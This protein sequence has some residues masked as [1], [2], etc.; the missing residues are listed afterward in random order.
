MFYMYA[1][2]IISQ[3]DTVDV[4]KHCSGFEDETGF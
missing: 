3:K 2:Q 1:G 4:T